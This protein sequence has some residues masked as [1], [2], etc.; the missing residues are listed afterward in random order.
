M[1]VGVP[2]DEILGQVLRNAVR[3]RLDALSEIADRADAASLLTVSRSEIPRLTGGW[4]TLLTAHEADDKGNC[5]ECS[6]AWRTRTAP[7]PVWRSAY[8]HLV[9]GAPTP[10]PARHQRPAQ[11]MRPAAP[12]P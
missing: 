9:A 12:V 8:E 7:C 3:E 6:S 4:R 11:R 10:G 5:P 2:V 1:T